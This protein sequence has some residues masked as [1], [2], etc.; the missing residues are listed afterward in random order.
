MHIGTMGWSYNFWKGAFYPQNLPAKDFLAYYSRK[1]N[2][3]EANSTFYRIPSEKTLAQWKK[4]TPD[5]FKFSLK[6]P[7]KITHL[8][9]LKNSQE[10]TRVFLE[11]A[12]L[13]EEKLGVLL[14]QLPPAFGSERFVDLSNFLTALPKNYHFA[15]EFRSKSM[16]SENV[17]ELLRDNKVSL[18][19]VDAARL[20]I[21]NRVT[22]D[23]I[24]LRWEGDRKAINGKKGQ[25]EED[26]TANIRDWSTRLNSFL[27]T[28]YEVFG[29]FSKYY[30][31]LPTSDVTE[32][33]R[34]MQQGAA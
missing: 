11:R 6:F 12:S 3:V 2:S 20:P 32:F 29:Y 25:T 24:Y 1:F 27:N 18:V 34:A 5:G 16:T 14:L 10:E 23:F 33:M 15:V 19:W 26:K 13:L 21:V 30:S 9:M 7:A 8:R 22:S 31:G 17:Y 4:Q 28:N